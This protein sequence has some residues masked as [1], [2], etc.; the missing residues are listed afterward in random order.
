MRLMLFVVLLG[1]V[2]AAPNRRLGEETLHSIFTLV[3]VHALTS[4]IYCTVLLPPPS[5]PTAPVNPA[6]GNVIEDEYIVVFNEGVT[7]EQGE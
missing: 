4:N 7:D 1:A 5:P 3:Y 2:Y 6:T